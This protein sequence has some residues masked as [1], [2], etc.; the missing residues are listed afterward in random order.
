MKK[1]LLVLAIIL[2]NVSLGQI[3]FD[4]GAK[5]GIGGT[6]PVNSNILNSDPDNYQIFQGA[7]LSYMYGFK[8]GINFNPIHSITPEINFSTLKPMYSSTVIEIP[9]FTYTQIPIVYRKNSDNGGYVEIGPQI[10]ILK[11]VTVGEN[12][13][14]ENFVKNTYDIVVG[15]GQ[16]IGG[17]SALGFNLGFRASM[18]LVDINADK[19]DRGYSMYTPVDINDYSYK[20]YRNIFVSI[21]LE[22]N[23]NFGYLQHGPNCHPGTRF[24]LF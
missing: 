23:L 24:K 10:S 18:P 22:V 4:I 5:G 6:A 7:K 14:T 20:P 16:Y 8:I 15:G 17:S 21:I 2:T 13:I 12:N 9:T 1:I 11:S 3:W 19:T